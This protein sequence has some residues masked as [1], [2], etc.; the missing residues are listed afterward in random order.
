MPRMSDVMTLDGATEAAA[1][2]WYADERVPPAFARCHPLV[3]AQARR[4]SGGDWRRCVLD[5]AGS[6]VVHHSPMW[7]REA[8]E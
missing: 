8:T 6:I 7:Q 1:V 5:D 4:L 2:A 3:V